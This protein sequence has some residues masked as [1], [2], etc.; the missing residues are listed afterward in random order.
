M[1]KLIMFAVVQNVVLSMMNLTGSITGILVYCYTMQRFNST[2]TDTEELCSKFSAQ[3]L[4]LFHRRHVCN[5]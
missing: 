5:C 4:I 2:T 1:E 3:N